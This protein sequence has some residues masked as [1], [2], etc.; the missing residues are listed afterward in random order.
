VSPTEILL[1]L[2]AT[3]DPLHSNQE[4]RYFHGYY[5]HC[6]YLPL[7][8]FMGDHLLC[9]R[10][11]PSNIDASAG[12][13]KEVAR[14]VAQIRQAWPEVGITLRGDSAFAAKI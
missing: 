2:D 12:Y 6:C 9:A 4:G 5:K 10:M 14:I 3:D 11:R 8:I 1:D 13:V 7:C